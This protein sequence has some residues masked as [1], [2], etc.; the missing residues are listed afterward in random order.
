MA[1]AWTRSIIVV[2]RPAVAAAANTALKDA[3]FDPEGGDKTFTVALRTAGDAT[4]TVAAYWAAGAV[5]PAMLTALR[6]RLQAAG[7][8]T[9]ETTLIPKTATL[10]S[11]ATQRIWCFDGAVWTPD[12]VLAF[13]GVDRTSSTG[14]A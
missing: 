8:T 14:P 7:A 1:T 13:L 4:N 2:L 12:E 3:T 11:V 9:A 6:T 5:K 10:A